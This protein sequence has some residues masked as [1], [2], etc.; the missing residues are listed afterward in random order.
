MVQSNKLNQD[1]MDGSVSASAIQN[2]DVSWMADPT[3]TPVF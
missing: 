3:A 1:N 2:V